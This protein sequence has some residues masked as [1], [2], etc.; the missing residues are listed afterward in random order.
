MR[1]IQE[2]NLREQLEQRRKQNIAELTRAHEAESKL[3]DE[4][5][6]TKATLTSE[7]ARTQNLVEMV[8]TK[9]H[10]LVG[11][12]QFVNKSFV[13]LFLFLLFVWYWKV[14]EYA[15]S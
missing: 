14:S 8:R 7:Y 4:L 13:D 12:L 10:K 11:L 6:Q 1:G 3:K 9:Q 2:R 15:A 5:E